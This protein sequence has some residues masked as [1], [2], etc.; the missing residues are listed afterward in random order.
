MPHCL[1][2]WQQKTAQNDG[3]TAGGG[4]APRTRPSGY[5]LYSG[6]RSFRTDDGIEIWPAPRFAEELAAGALWP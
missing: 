5:C 6:S 1:S 3:T 2:V 4:R